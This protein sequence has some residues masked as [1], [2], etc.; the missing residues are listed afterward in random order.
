MVEALGAS[1]LK[2]VRVAIGPLRIGG[3]EVGKWR[4]L[5]PSERAALIP[6][7]SLARKASTRLV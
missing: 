7:R 4:Y 2:L 1:V 3:L 6:H 5:E